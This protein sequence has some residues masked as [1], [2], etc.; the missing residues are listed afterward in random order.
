[1][2]ERLTRFALGSA[3]NEA[4]AV[5]WLAR[6]GRTVVEHVVDAVRERMA[7][8]RTPGMR[9]S[10]AG[11][12]VAVPGRSAG[13]GGTVGNVAGNAP[14]NALGNVAGN[15]AWNASGNAAGNVA[16]NAVE[17]AAP[18]RARAQEE[19]SQVLWLRVEDMAPG[20]WGG[21]GARAARGDGARVAHGEPVSR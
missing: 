6:F 11:R 3:A 12:S 20:G 19:E 9:G 10:V 18:G 5:A 8:L 2:T 7:A 1:M 21:W 17:G 16:W 15:V 4:V 14:G 13:A